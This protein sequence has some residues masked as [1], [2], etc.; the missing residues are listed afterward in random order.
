MSIFDRLDRVA[1]RTVDRI[2]KIRLVLTPWDRTPN[3]R[4][5]QDPDRAVVTC[6]GIF[7]YVSIEHG[8]ELGVRKSYREANDLRAL[9]VG[10]DPQ[11]SIDRIY[12]P[13]GADEPRQ[14]DRV[15]FPD[16]PE[17]PEFEVTSAQRDGLS[18]MVIK[19]AHRGSQV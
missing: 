16:N 15:T 8:L 10:R 2:N 3:G 4:G 18:R 12:F 9:Q 19:L 13:T 14:G 17:L 7:D 1:S 6:K 5:D 11:V